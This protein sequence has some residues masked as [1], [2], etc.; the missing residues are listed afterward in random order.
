MRRIPI[1]KALARGLRL[2]VIGV[3]TWAAGQ[4]QAGGISVSPVRVV[5]TPERSVSAIT[6]TNTS[7]ET[8][9]IE[10]ETLPWPADAEAQTPKDITVNPP[11]STLAPGEKVTVRVGLVRR[12][13]STVERSYRL[14]FTELPTLRSQDAQGVGVRLRLGIPLFVAAGNAAPAALEWSAQREGEALMVTAL[15]PGN[16][17]QRITRL[18]AAQGARRFDAAQSSPYVLPSR[19]TVFRL[20]GLAVKSGERL[21]LQ[22]ETD[23]GSRQ[24]DVLVP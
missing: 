16:V 11:I 23:G 7:R 10:A 3:C 22:V 2:A 17:H 8:L 19:S 9:T 24:V 1:T 12:L 18:T 20:P 13:P 14:Y 15:N 4:A 21:S 5:F 6:L